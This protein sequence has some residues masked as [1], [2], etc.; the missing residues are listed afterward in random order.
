MVAG[1]E[2][3]QSPCTNQCGID[4]ATGW[5]D[6]CARTLDE[7]ACWGSMSDDEKRR[8]LEL[9]NERLRQRGDLQ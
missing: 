4:P 9:V 7:I 2:T 1:T 8:V 6:G 5:C 3:P